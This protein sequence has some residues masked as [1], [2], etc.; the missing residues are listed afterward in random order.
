MWVVEVCAGLLPVGI[1]P[2]KTIK[3]CES[4]RCAQGCALGSFT[5]K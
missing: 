1:I 4:W 2:C 3:G 5:I